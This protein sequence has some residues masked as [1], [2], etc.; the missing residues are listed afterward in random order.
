V[1]GPLLAQGL[2]LLAR[3][4]GQIWPGRPGHPVRARTARSPRRVHAHGGVGVGSSPVIKAAQGWQDERSL[5]VADP[6][7]KDTRVAAHRS[8][9]AA[10]RRRTSFGRRRGAPVVHSG[11]GGFLKRAEVTRRVRC[12]GNQREKRSRRHSLIRCWSR[13][14]Q[15]R[16]LWRQ[17]RSSSGG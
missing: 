17:R 14:R 9:A 2:S 12:T 11:G 8:G 13:Q 6:L 5:G 10:V 7:G 1:L 16:F 4:S 15:L 3:P